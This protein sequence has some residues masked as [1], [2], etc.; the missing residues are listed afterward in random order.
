MQ[1]VYV[2]LQT[3]FVAKQR[4]SSRLPV[5]PQ[6]SKIKPTSLLALH[7][8]IQPQQLAAVEVCSAHCHFKGLPSPECNSPVLTFTSCEI[9]RFCRI[10]LIRK[11]T[12]LVANS[13]P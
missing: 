1:S 9:L 3:G 2:E 6:S 4:S 11:V 12:P 13:N 5:T 7:L 8:A 10:E